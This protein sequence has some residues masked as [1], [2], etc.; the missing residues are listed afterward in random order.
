[1]PVDQAIVAERGRQ[2]QFSRATLGW[3]LALLACIAAFDLWIA[4]TPNRV[5]LGTRTTQ[6]TF[7]PVSLGPP[8]LGSARLG[9]LRLAGAWRLASRDPRFGGISALAFDSGALF[10]LTDSGAIVRFGLPRGTTGLAT[11]RE[12]PAGPSDGRFKRDRDSESLVRDSAGRGWWVAFE[13]HNQLWLFD[14]SFT[15]A[16]D[17]IQLP[18]ASWHVNGGVEAMARDGDGLLLFVESGPEVLRL[19]DRK[20]S[21]QSIT[22][23]RGT[24]TDAITLADGRILAIDREL[25]PTGFS[26]R[27]VTIVRR[28]EGLAVTGGVRLP[29]RA[30][31]NAEG[32]AAQPLPGGGTRL[33]LVTDD[34]FQLPFRTLLVA[35]DLK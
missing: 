19:A 17:R 30:I 5:V 7:D 35:L 31:D 9:P 6:V 2:P 11:I 34:N 18:G 4:T 12:L 22:G 16:L 13:R 15:R 10:A 3:L 20:V 27:V 14:P 29:L 24:I 23:Q 28:R 33:W 1:M 26:T 32:L 25:T 8:S 21:P